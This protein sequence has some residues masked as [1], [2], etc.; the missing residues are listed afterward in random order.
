MIDDLLK[1]HCDG[2]RYLAHHPLSQAAQ[3]SNAASLR[4]VLTQTHRMKCIKFQRDNKASPDFMG[5]CVRHRLADDGESPPS[6]RHATTCRPSISFFK[7]I[8]VN[9]RRYTSPRASSNTAGPERVFN[10]H[11]LNFKCG[12]ILA[13]IRRA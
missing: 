3:K 4:L 2:S 1:R 9:S 13:Y 7:N 8:W 11:T 12:A 6:S 10:F 5:W